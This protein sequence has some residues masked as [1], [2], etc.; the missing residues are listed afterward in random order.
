MK[1]SLRKNIELKKALAE[2]DRLT[3]ENVEL[4]ANLNHQ[5]VLTKHWKEA[6]DRKMNKIWSLTNELI[7]KFA[8]NGEEYKLN[9][10]GWL[11]YEK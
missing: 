6:S 5:I 4:K 9:G 8:E 11:N 1:P 10:K 7:E 3:S 2:V